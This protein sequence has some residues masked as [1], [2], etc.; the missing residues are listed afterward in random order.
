MS[1]RFYAEA[2]YGNTDWQVIQ[3]NTVTGAHTVIKQYLQKEEARALADTMQGVVDTN[4]ERQ[5]SPGEER[6]NWTN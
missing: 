1:L 3:E 4:R 2:M 6:E 5:E